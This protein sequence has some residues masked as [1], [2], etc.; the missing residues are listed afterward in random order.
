MTEKKNELSHGAPV[1]FVAAER[2]GVRKTTSAAA[3][4]SFFL[5]RGIEVALFQIDD[6]PTL[7][8]AFGSRVKTIRLPTAEALRTD[9]LADAAA[10]QP[11]FLKL[12][13]S[14]EVVVVDCGA[15][16]DIRLFDAAAA[17][18]LDHELAL[19]ARPVTVI[20]PTTTDPDAVLLACRT[21]ERACTALPQ[22]RVVPMLCEDGGNFA[23]LGTAAAQARYNEVLASL[24]RQHVLK[25]PRLLPRV[26]GALARTGLPAWNVPDLSVAELKEHLREPSILA[27]YIRGD[28]VEWRARMEAELS[29]LFAS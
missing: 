19:A 15:N 12:L 18:D 22:S 26:L 8:A 1:I 27:R 7:P 6:Q 10:L 24:A 28:V 14:E 3:I 25:H 23:E 2:G 21:A 13:E 11:L 20:V 16:T 9:D 17:I 4:T 29:R 5:A